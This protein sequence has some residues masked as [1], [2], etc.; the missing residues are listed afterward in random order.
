MRLRIFCLSPSVYDP[1]PGNTVEDK[2]R[3]IC[4]GGLDLRVMEA[5]MVSF[6]PK[7]TLIVAG[8]WMPLKPFKWTSNDSQ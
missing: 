5:I 7:Q 2:I 4:R 3:R 8:K 1:P 6:F